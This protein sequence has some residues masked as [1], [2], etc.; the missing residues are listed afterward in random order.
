MISY[1]DLYELLRKEKF[2]EN[3]QALP[4][5]FLDEFSEYIQ[6]KREQ[7]NISD[8]F[9][10]ATTKTKK[11]LENSIALFKELMLRRKKK[12]LNLVFIAAETGIMKR[13]YENMLSF[14]RELFEKLVKSFEEEDKEIG[15]I[16]NGKKGE[17]ENKNKMIIFKQ[18]VE[19]FVDMFGNVVGPFM[20]GELA[21]L[22]A[23]VCEIL[24]SSGKASFVDEA[25][26]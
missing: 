14:E 15:K 2:S 25:V 16:F 21:N 11:Q 12:I 17:V 13:D 23:A 24:V 26:K 9:S 18:N 22:D 10:D 6:E 7:S 8:F 1:N 20:A 4:K 3:L 5:N 19:Q